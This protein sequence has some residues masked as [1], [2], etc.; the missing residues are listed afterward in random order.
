[1]LAMR[2]VRLI[3]AHSDNLS[4][5]LAEQIRKSERASDFRKIPTEDLRLA[6]TEVY[7]NLGE[8]LLQKT[9]RDIAERFRA[10]AARRSAEG[11]GLDQFVWALMLSRDHLWHFLRHESFADNIVALHG[12]M[13]LLNLLNHFFDRAI[14]HAIVGYT[15]AAESEVKSELQRAR[16]LAISIG[17]MS[18]KNDERF[19]ESGLE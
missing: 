4:R 5:G 3:E 7:R 2:L 6:A 14:Y 11:I 12:E 16:D 9:E 8:W 15:E 18:A 13:E 17:L 1:M 10:V 19:R